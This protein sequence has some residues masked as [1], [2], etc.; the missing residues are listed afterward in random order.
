MTYLTDRPINKA[1]NDLL[2]RANFSKQLG[3]SICEYNGTEGL[4]I[5]LFGKWGTGKTS[6]INMAIGEIEHQTK[7]DKNKPLIMH[8]S[9]WNYSDKNNLIGQFFKSLENKVKLKGYERLEKLIG[10][11]LQNYSWVIDGLALVAIDGATIIMIIKL[12]LAVIKA[13]LTNKPSL[14]TAKKTLES[15]LRVSDNKIIVIIDDIDRLTNSQIRDIFQ[16]VKQVG[17]FSNIIYVLVM[18]REVVCRALNEVHNIDGKEYL[19]KIVQVPFEIPEIN[20]LNLRQIFLTKI[21]Q[22]FAEFSKEN[23]DQVYW[24]EIFRNCIEPYVK[25]LRDV[26]RVVNTLRFRYGILCK[27]TSFEDMVAITTIE[28]LEPALYQWISNNKDRVCRTPIYSLS[29]INRNEQDNNRELYIK[30]FSNINIEPV[31]AINF[32][33]TIFPAFESNIN[34]HSYYREEL[35][36]R[37]NKR[38]ADENKFELYFM[39]N[40]DDIKISRSIIEDCIFKYDLETL[41]EVIEEIDQQGNSQYFLEEIDAFIEKIPEERLALIASSL[42]RKKNGFHGEELSQ[43]Y[44][45]FVY[46][47]AETLIIRL[48]RKIEMAEKRYAIIFSAVNEVSK[49]NLGTIA[50]VI[51]TIKIAHGNQDGESQ[52]IERQIISIDHLNKIEKLY[53]T[54]LNDIIKSHYIFDLYKGSSAFYLWQCLDKDSAE[55]Y[56]KKLLNSDINVLKFIC[57]IASRWNGTDGCGWDFNLDNYSSFITKEKIFNIIQEFNKTELCKFSKINQIKLASFVLNYDKN[58]WDR[59]NEVDAQKLVDKWGEIE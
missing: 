30:E 24:S 10:P 45:T 33:T 18:D 12:I 9:P 56:L 47:T 57:A 29:L 49:Y 1:E 46:D 8:F 5:G 17:D 59:V 31:R 40:L 38:V 25:T 28:V 35:S 42:L 2:G 11:A 53:L 55:K 26:N 23:I 19:E 44:M 22:V 52:T 48:I 58:D 37:R 43:F 14:D 50:R 13:K 54:K 21:E 41:S 16:L 39:Y 4:V 32:L 20:K 27:E 6:V 36:I 15:A 3:K 7:N 51:N 34:S